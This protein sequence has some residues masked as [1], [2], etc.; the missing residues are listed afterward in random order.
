MVEVHG[1]E[2]QHVVVLPLLHAVSVLHDKRC[3]LRRTRLPSSSSSSAAGVLWLRV[4]LLLL[5]RQDED[6][7]A[8]HPGEV[9]QPHRELL[10]VRERR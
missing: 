3:L 2:R 5:V 1:V 8:R 6:G 4:L 9:H 7:G 10:Q